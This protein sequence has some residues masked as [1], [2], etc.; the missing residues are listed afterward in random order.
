MSLSDDR[1]PNIW[2]FEIKWKADKTENTMNGIAKRL[3]FINTLN[4]THSDH[5][6]V[7]INIDLPLVWFI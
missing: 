5:G 2:K 1:D 7:N 4:T 3:K 6:I